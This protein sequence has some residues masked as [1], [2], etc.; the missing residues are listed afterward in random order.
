MKTNNSIA[1]IMTATLTA[2]IVL[3]GS[4]LAKTAIR[5]ERLKYDSMTYKLN[6][7]HDE[8]A[9]QYRFSSSA[10]WP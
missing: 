9:R 5:N 7:A 6:A 10:K 4:S 8:I 1:L 2:L 3:S